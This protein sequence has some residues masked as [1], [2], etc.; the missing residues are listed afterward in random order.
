MQLADI[1]DLK[2]RFCG[3]D[4]RRRYKR[5]TMS[6]KI[7]K[8]QKIGHQV[9]RF[10]Q[11]SI[12]HFCHETKLLRWRLWAFK[13]PCCTMVRGSD[14]QTYWEE[15][16]GTRQTPIAVK[17]LVSLS[18]GLG[19]LRLFIRKGE[20]EAADKLID[21]LYDDDLYDEVQKHLC[22]IENPYTLP[23]SMRTINFAE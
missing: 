19:A 17:E 12:V 11:Y 7:T 23:K 15:K 5:E 21:D 4:F 2:S 20:T 1:L 16:L 18:G 22:L 13:I 6:V 10:E 14:L 8:H 3:F 9:W